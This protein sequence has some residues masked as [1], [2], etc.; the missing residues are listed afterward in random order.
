MRDGIDKVAPR[1]GVFT[2]T[3]RRWGGRPFESSCLAP[4][5]RL[6]LFC[7]R[8]IEPDCRRPV[9]LV[10][11]VAAVLACSQPRSAGAAEPTNPPDAEQRAQRLVLILNGA[12]V[13]CFAVWWWRGRRQKSGLLPHDSTGGGDADRLRAGLLP[14][15]ARWMSSEVFHGIASQQDVLVK[16]Q[17]QAAR[18]MAEL[19]E[20]LVKIHAPLEERLKAYEKRIAELEQELAA[21]HAE[22]CELLEA[23]IQL[24]RRK[25]AAERSREETPGR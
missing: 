17:Q 12:A 6:S 5:L 24:A 20:R 8:T 3:M 14:H 11:T 19:E 1:D 22:N 16:C 7:V 4:A 10:F 21:K 23:R 15:L 2:G 9:V 13:I 25:L 18:E